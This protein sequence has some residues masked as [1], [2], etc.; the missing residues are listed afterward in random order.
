MGRIKVEVNG[1]LAMLREE[2]SMETRE[3][4]TREAWAV[5]DRQTLVCAAKSRRVPGA[6]HMSRAKLLDAIVAI[7]LGKDR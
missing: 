2:T 1:K 4:E 7:E 6:D 5:E 3:R